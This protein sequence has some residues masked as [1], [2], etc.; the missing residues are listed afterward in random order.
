MLPA[1]LRS[2][3]AASAAPLDRQARRGKEGGAPVNDRTPGPGPGTPPPRRSVIRSGGLAA[4]AAGLL[5]TI[6]PTPAPV[7]AGPLAGD[8][9][10]IDRAEA[11]LLEVETLCLSQLSVRDRNNISQECDRLS[12]VLGALDPI[13]AAAEWPRETGDNR[14]MDRIDHLEAEAA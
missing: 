11:L 5:G 10:P 12:M 13:A 4:L 2:W 3:P 1:V 6:T 8:V 14:V 7:A 9:L